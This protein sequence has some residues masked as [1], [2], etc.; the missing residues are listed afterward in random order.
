MATVVTDNF[1]NANMGLPGGSSTT[2]D[3]DTDDV[4]NSLIDEAQ[5]G[6]LDETASTYDDIDG[7]SGAVADGAAMTNKTVGVVSAGV[8]DSTVDYT[9][10]SVTGAE[11]EYLCL[12]KYDAT[13][14]NATL[15]VIW[16]SATTGL[17]VSPNSGDI[18]VT[19]N[20]SGIL[21]I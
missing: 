3:W 20:A 6:A 4:R 13:P 17:P 10:A 1:R 11:C 7:G 8:F 18:T 2:I 16:D 19:W 21:T 14:A 5:S 12:F 15:A 9:F